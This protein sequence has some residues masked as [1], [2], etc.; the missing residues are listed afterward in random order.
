MQLLDKKK[1]AIQKSIERETEVKEGMKLA[2]KVDA[3]REMAAN[4]E[5]KLT[6]FRMESLKI[7]KDEINVLVTEK[8][9]LEAEITSIKDRRTELQKP[10]DSSWDDLKRHRLLFDIE[11]ENFRQNASALVKRQKEHDQ[12]LYELVMQEERIKEKDT[13]AA[14]KLSQTEENRLKTAEIL[15]KMEVNKD[16]FD[17]NCLVKN[18]ELLTRQAKIAS[19][20]REL[21][22]EKDQLTKDRQE[23]TAE[24][25]LVEDREQTLER[26]IN[27]RKNG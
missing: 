19:R 24:R 23:L 18:Q 4:E 20:E 27:R 3:L 26:E 8:T 7:I 13:Q 10:L 2:K 1:I 12:R 11:R 15:S 14:E 25:V 22:L 6:K 17:K 21:G 9:A 5:S 16:D